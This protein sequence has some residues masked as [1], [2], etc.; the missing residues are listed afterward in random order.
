MFIC[1]F[2]SISNLMLNYFDVCSGIQL[3]GKTT[4][5]SF[6]CELYSL[7]LGQLNA[8]QQTVILITSNSSLN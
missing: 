8:F 4:F 6:L 2:T 7:M 5:M 1:L 3:K